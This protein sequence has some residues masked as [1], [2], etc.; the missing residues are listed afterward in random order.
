MCGERYRV[1]SLLLVVCAGRFSQKIDEP[2]PPST[3]RTHR[4][5]KSTAIHVAARPLQILVIEP[6]RNAAKAIATLLHQ[7]GHTPHIAADATAS[8][9]TVQTY[10]PD[11]ILLNS[12]GS[13]VF[14][15]AAKLCEA[16]VL[17]DQFLIKPAEDSTLEMLLSTWPDNSAP[18]P[19]PS[20]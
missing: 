8:L 2:G 10:R 3:I 5:I 7:W 17:T 19:Q 11:V 6:N 9:A 15:I 16:G 20:P 18:S 14:K 1:G 12:I 4:H 13:G